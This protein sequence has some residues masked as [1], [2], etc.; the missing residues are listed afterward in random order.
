VAGRGVASADSLTTLLG[1]YRPGATITIGWVDQSGGQHT[2][3][4]T[5]A[6][7]PAH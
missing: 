5:L 2:S 1:G 7:G 3:T 4:V 6:S